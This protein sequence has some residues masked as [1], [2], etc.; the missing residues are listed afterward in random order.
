MLYYSRITQVFCF[1]FSLVFFI[2]FIFLTYTRTS[3]VVIFIRQ[4]FLLLFLFFFHNFT[5]SL[6]DVSQHR[7]SRVS[8]PTVHVS[9]V[10]VDSLKYELRTCWFCRAHLLIPSRTFYTRGYPGTYVNHTT[11][12]FNGEY[13]MISG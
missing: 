1:I 5:R 8:R 9:A 11:T 7:V 2:A 10:C 6:S 12:V 4:F 3:A 13:R